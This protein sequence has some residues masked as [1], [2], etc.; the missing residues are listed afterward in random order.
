MISELT[1]KVFPQPVSLKTVRVAC[2]GDGQALDRISQAAA[3]RW[4]LD[5]I[6]FETASRSIYLRLG[7]PEDVNESLSGEI[8]SLWG[9][10]V[11][12]LDD[13][14]ARE[15]WEAIGELDS[16]LSDGEPA[17]VI[18]VPT[19]PDD[20]LSLRRSLSI[21]GI[22]MRLS[23]AGAA[24]W[25]RCDDEGKL[26]RTAEV[27]IEHQL[28]GMCVVGSSSTPWIGNRDPSSVEGRVKAAMDPTHK[29]PL[30]DDTPIA[31]G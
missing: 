25:I 11:E 4:E 29:F 17:A 24:T 10:D 21:D 14:A 22:D 9:S 7:G 15:I 2:E 26:A 30:L 20:F 1:F 19:T 23:V 6:E 13:E 8:Q 28:V 27:L 12:P 31:T 16:A 5:A 18:K 3:S